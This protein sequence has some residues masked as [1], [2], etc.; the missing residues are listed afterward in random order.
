MGREMLIGHRLLLMLEVLTSLEK[1][2]FVEW[3]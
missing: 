1:F 2:P 3:Y